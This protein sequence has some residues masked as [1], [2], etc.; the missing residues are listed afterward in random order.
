MHRFNKFLLSAVVCTLWVAAAFA[1]PIAEHVVLVSI[2]GASPRVMLE[3]DMPVLMEMAKEGAHTWE[4]Q[5][6][7]PSVTLI[8]HTSMM[9]GVSPAK[10]KTT[11]NDWKPDQD[12]VSVTTMFAEAKK[13]EW[14]TAFFSGKGKLEYLNIPGSLDHCVTPAYES[15]TVADAAAAYIVEKKPNLTFVHFAEPDGA[16]HKHKWG[17]D[18]Q[19]AS[20]ADADKAL[21]TV[22]KAVEDA[23][24]A[25]TTVFIVTAD[26]GGHENTHGTNSPEDMTIPWV[27]W[28]KGV[29]AGFDITEDVTVYDSAATALYILDVP[30]PKEWDGKAIESAFAEA[31]VAVGVN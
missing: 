26:H 11:K 20:L 15:Q 6:I 27:V 9:T 19:K 24:I 23:G 18:E 17:S 12:P 13:L 7:M 30:I 21:A 25:D 31:P 28:G 3:S 4:A 10:H 5:T 22:K 14:N 16:G 29:K 2:D 8:A 1:A